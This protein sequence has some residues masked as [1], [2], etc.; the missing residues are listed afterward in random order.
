M[1][2]RPP[3]PTTESDILKIRKH[4]PV[5]AMAIRTVERE[6]QRQYYGSR[7]QGMNKTQKHR[8][9]ATVIALIL[10]IIFL[11]PSIAALVIGLGYDGTA[12]S[13]AHNHGNY[14]IDLF[15]YLIVAGS[16]PIAWFAMYNWLQNFAYRIEINWWIFIIAGVVAILI[17]MV[18]VSFQAIKTAIANPIDSLR[19]E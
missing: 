2:T 7:S 9:E 6:E 12:S 8:L 11:A 16:I 17:A 19:T 3:A 10:N 13:C 4:D 18:T 15:T 14:T 5:L 1:S